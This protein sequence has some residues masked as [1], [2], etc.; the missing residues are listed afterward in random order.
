MTFEVKFINMG[1]KKQLEQDYAKTL[2]ID[3]GLNQKEIALRLKVS[4]KTIGIWAKTGGWDKLK[5]S[6]LVTKDNQLTMLYDQLDF[7]NNDI[8][9]RDFKIATAKEADTISKLTSAIKKLETETA[10]GDTVEIC[11][12]I[13]QFI[14]QQD[15]EFANHLVKYCDSFINQKMK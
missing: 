1:V 4:Q 11:K 2:F 15:I 8:K 10:I 3:Q 6:M 7:I 5:K 14:R 12:Q 9:N 13:I